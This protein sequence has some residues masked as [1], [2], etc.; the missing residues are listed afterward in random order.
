MPSDKSAVYDELIKSDRIHGRLYYDPAVYHDEMEK[1]WHRGWVYVGHESEV[2]APGDYVTR[3]VGQQPIIMVRSHDKEI[4]LLVNRCRHR[5]NLVCQNERGNASFFRCDYHGW[6]YNTRG[7]LIRVTYADGYGESFNKENYGLVKTP[8]MAVYRGF[9]FA[10]LQPSGISLDNHLAGAKE[11]IDMFVELAPLGEIELS[12]GAQKVRYRGNWKMIAENSLEGSYHGPVLHQHFFDM[13]GSR[14]GLNRSSPAIAEQPGHIRYLPG[15]HMVEDFRGLRYKPGRSA[16]AISPAGWQAYVAAMERSYGK[17]KAQQKIEDRS[18]FI[19]IFPNLIL[20]QTHVRRIQP[21]DVEQ[22]AVSYQPALLKGTPEEINIARLREHEEA[23]G[24]AGFLSAD[25]LEIC[26]RNQIGVKAQ[27]EEWLLISR[28]IN[29][30][31]IRSDGVCIGYGTDEGQ[32]RGLWRH[33][34]E[35]MRQ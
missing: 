28:G 24:P 35:V 25:D 16:V 1:I 15:G 5:G 11:F 10:S 19:Y 3:S 33:Y 32:L 21:V 17:E 7:E 12:A 13:A 14:M 2:R 26:E 4:Q 31:E 27:G 6:T 34:R 29:R 9:V 30:E 20:L 22:T 18:Q 23:F 8:R